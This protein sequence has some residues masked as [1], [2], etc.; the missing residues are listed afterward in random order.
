MPSGAHVIQPH[1]Q[2]CNCLC[3]LIYD[4]WYRHISQKSIWIMDFFWQIYD[5][6]IIPWPENPPE[7]SIYSHLLLQNSGQAARANVTSVREAVLGAAFWSLQHV[8]AGQC[9]HFMWYIN[10]VPLCFFL[11][12]DISINEGWVICLSYSIQM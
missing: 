3:A 12:C 7:K 8:N 11:Q 10:P 5:S 9:T 1:S 6:S 4:L 2:K